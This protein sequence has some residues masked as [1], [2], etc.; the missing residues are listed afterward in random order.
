MER[1]GDGATRRRGDEITTGR[2]LSLT[3]CPSVSSS[4]FRSVAPSLCLSVSKSQNAHNR[5]AL[6]G[7]AGEGVRVTRFKSDSLAILSGEAERAGVI[8]DCIIRVF[9]N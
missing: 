7:H 2:R 1:R 3:R 9:Q 4:L 8:I 6:G 5:V